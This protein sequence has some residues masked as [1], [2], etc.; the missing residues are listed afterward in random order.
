MA[1]IVL[2]WEANSSQDCTELADKFGFR[3]WGL[4]CGEEKW[5]RLVPPGGNVTQHCCYWA[6]VPPYLPVGSAA[7]PLAGLD[8]TALAPTVQRYFQEGLAPSTRS[9]Y[10]SAMKEF[11]TFCLRH[12][13]FD[14]FP[15]TEYL[16]CCFAAFMAEEGPS[17]LNHTYQQFVTL[18]CHSAYRIPENSLPSQY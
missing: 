4:C 3:K 11:T 15:V 2:G 16:L 18:S 9:V 13:V 7:G 14:P 5:A 6:Q 12:N 8:L 17:P 10:N 1:C